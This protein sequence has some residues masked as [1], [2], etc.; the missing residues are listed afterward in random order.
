M[1]PG[2][3][4]TYLSQKNT[5]FHSENGGGDTGVT[6]KNT[7]RNYTHRSDKENLL[8]VWG[9]QKKKNYINTEPMMIR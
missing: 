7:A 3:A 1:R 9:S 4:T 8:D 6:D 5:G 2:R